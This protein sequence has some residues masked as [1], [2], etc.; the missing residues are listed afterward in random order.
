MI[1][2]LIVTI[3]TY[4]E[5][6]PTPL[7]ALWLSFFLQNFKKF[8]FDRT[9]QSFSCIVIK[10]QSSL[11]S[12]L[13]KAFITTSEFFPQKS[14][15]HGNKTQCDLP[16]DNRT[17]IFWSKKKKQKLIVLLL[18]SIE[19]KHL[20]MNVIEWI[21]FPVLIGREKRNFYVAILLI[22]KP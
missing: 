18:F 22:M 9:V 10:Y 11:Q 21:F 4:Y 15:F 20:Y 7:H 1:L 14:W 5:Y 6:L 17:V 16:T 2:L 12:A 3:I 13:L 19:H 8:Y